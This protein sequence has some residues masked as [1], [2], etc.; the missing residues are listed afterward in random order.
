V[1]KVQG[2]PYPQA[3]LDF[4]SDLCLVSGPCRA[5]PRETRCITA[6]ELDALLEVVSAALDRRR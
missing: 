5:P 4:A 6:E 3:D 2:R 1:G